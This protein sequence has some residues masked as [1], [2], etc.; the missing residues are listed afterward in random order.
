MN[1]ALFFLALAGLT[2][3]ARADVKPHPLF[4][5]GMVLQQGMKCPVWG[6]AEPGEEISVELDLGDMGLGV[7]GNAARDGTWR[8]DIHATKVG[9]P[10]TLRIKGK[11]TV[12][13]KDV[14]VGEVWVASGQSNMQW[15]VN[16][17]ADPDKVRAAA[18]DPL[19]RFFTVPHVPADEPKKDVNA[20]WVAASPETV[21]GFSAVAYHFARHLREA[22]KVPVGILH[23]SWG[24]TYAEAWTPT[25]YLESIPSLKRVVD[26]YRQNRPNAAN[27]FQ[28]A[29]EKHKA[30]L[31]THKKAVEEAKRDGRRPPPAPRPPVNPATTPNRPSVLFDGMIAPLQPY[32]IKGAIWYQGESNAGRAWEYRTLFPTMIR[33]WRETWKQGDFPFLFV[34]LAPF[35]PIVEQPQ[36]SNWAELREAQL[37]TS[38]TVPHTAMA[39]ITDAGD[40]KD[41][42]PKQKAGAGR[43]LAYGEK[44]THSGPL[45]DEMKVEGY[46]VVLRFKHAGAGLEARGGDLK[47][48]TV[49]GQDRK[50]RNAR[51]EIQGDQVVV[52]SDEVDKPVAVRYG[53]YNC[54]VVNL[55]NKDGLPASPFRTDTFPVTTQR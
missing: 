21:G 10:F 1:R 25:T 27:D 7:K 13:I 33:A 37:F 35:M 4:S 55:W 39:V 28:R 2:A 44:I 32:A 50:F 43:A 24:G 36:D 19:V 54:P 20:R 45:Y 48:F 52:W 26:N 40:P 22:R 34:Q 42:H 11:N 9:G 53:W 6:T 51:A 47:G 8:F 23:T 14:H 16:Q 15:S 17:S 12:T 5:D 18:K 49:A 46:K 29:L 38:Q 30:D 41:I 3:P 31:E